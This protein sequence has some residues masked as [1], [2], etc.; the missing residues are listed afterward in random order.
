VYVD[1]ANKIQKLKVGTNIK[2]A[3]EFLKIVGRKMVSTV[4]E[5]FVVCPMVYR[6]GIFKKSHVNL[7]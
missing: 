2:Y 1:V 5:I 7:Y 6:S 4:M 3:C